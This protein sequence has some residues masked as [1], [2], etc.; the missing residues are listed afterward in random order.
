MRSSLRWSAGRIASRRAGRGEASHSP[1]QRGWPGDSGRTAAGPGDYSNWN[2]LD[3]GHRLRHQTSSKLRQVQLVDVDHHEV[4]CRR[5]RPGRSRRVTFGP[6][7]PLQCGQ[8]RSPASCAG[9]TRSVTPP[10]RP[11]TSCS[12]MVP[13]QHPATALDGHRSVIAV[14]ALA[15][16]LW[17]PCNQSTSPPTV[18]GTDDQ[19]PRSCRPRSAH[20]RAYCRCS[21]ISWMPF[22]LG[23]AFGRSRP[24]VSGEAVRASRPSSP[25]HPGRCSVSAPQSGAHEAPTSSC[26]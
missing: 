10:L 14:G 4:A 25:I 5:P 21:S 15:A 16:T 2:A 13:R 17:R 1:H 7:M 24:T 8:P 12:R 23:L 22:G 26:G 6:A 20:W 3:D 9:A 19:R 18:R 11:G